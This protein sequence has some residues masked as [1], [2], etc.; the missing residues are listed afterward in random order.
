MNSFY[1]KIE[2]TVRPYVET[3]RQNG[4]NTTASCEHDGY[5]LATSLDSTKEHIAI[6]HVLT[7]LFQLKEWTAV[8]TVE[9]FH[10][11]YHNMWEIES[12]SFIVPVNMGDM[13]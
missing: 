9:H 7:E 2:E 1:A 10:G 5:I 6:S 12:H 11:S 13:F 8:L 4:I 3:L